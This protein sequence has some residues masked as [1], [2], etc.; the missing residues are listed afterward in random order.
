MPTDGTVNRERILDAA[1]H[2]VIENGFSATSVD[3]VIKAAATSKGA[4]FHHFATKLDLAQALT[5]RYVNA[6]LGHLRAALQATATAADPAERVVAF[7][8]HFEE[9]ADE[10][11]SAQSS[12]LYVA[13]LTEQQ[14][15][16]N[17]TAD[18]INR[19]IEAW[20]K[21]IADLLTAAAAS[22]DVDLD[23]LDA[24]ADHVFVTFEGAFLLCR[25]TGSSEH[26]RAQLRVLRHLLGAV[27]GLPRAERIVGNA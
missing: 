1:E 23:D 8:R 13:V 15:V 14:L 24:L 17:G 25:S 4:F 21:E 18:L 6:D 2:L 19:A 7:V 16:T 9:A 22:R 26:M 12:C 10:M 20:R 3:Q 5:T 11:M 27:L